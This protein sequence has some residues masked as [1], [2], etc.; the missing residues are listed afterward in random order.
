MGFEKVF[1]GPGESAEVAI[2]IAPDRLAYYHDEHHKWVIEAGSYELDIG[3]SVTDIRA[4]LPLELTVGTKPRTVYTLESVIGEIIRDPRG[5]AV[6]DF[7]MSV[8]AGTPVSMADGDPFFTAILKNLPFK[9]IANF[10]RGAV[11]EQQLLG[12][13]M[14]INSE[15]TPEQVKATL[16][17]YAPPPA[18]ESG[19]ENGDDPNME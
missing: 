8:Q 9:R 19:A 12:L 16:S 5:M 17:Q 13:L 6:M 15:M 1:L 4:S 2:G 3:A 11:N 7:M 10:S 18:E 14:M